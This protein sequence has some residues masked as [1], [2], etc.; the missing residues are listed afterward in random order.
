MARVVRLLAGW[1]ARAVIHIS[2]CV[3]PIRNNPDLG[4]LAK[5]VGPVDDDFVAGLEP[6]HDLDAVAVGDARLN[7]LDGDRIVRLDE[8]YE[9]SR[10]ALLD[11]RDL[12]GGRILEVTPKN[13]R[14]T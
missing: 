8:E 6:R 5:P 7:L 1:S 14:I 10:P 2:Y 12:D 3:V 13:P 4:S 11:R 9:S